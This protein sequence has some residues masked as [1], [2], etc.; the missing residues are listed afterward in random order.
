VGLRAMR[1]LPAERLR[2]AQGRRARESALD[3]PVFLDTPALAWVLGAL[4]QFHRIPFDE[5]LVLG[6]L[7]P[8][9][10]YES[11]VQAAELLGLKAG[12]REKPASALKELAAPFVAVLSSVVCEPQ[13]GSG[14]AREISASLDY[15]A[16]GRRLA[17]VLRV[18]ED[19]VAFFEQG[20]PGHSIL[21]LAEF[22]A[23][24]LGPA[25]SGS[26]KWTEKLHDDTPNAFGVTIDQLRGRMTIS[27][28]SQK[29]PA[30]IWRHS[31][32]GDGTGGK[33]AGASAR[34]DVDQIVALISVIVEPGLAQPDPQTK[35]TISRRN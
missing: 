9:Y 15:G 6:Q 17:F 26:A 2:K 28:I 31:D 8:P 23:R 18:E 13:N 5:K 19:R 35:L 11:M 20:R 16:P 12:W 32:H 7:A 24:Y 4:A 25:R 3:R 29:W 14:A 33:G 34:P 21:S 10:G 27:M 1:S 30:R 22:Q